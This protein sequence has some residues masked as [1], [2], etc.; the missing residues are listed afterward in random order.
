MPSGT[1]LLQELLS[2][3]NE[4]VK[5]NTNTNTHTNVNTNTNANTNTT[6]ASWSADEK[7]W[8]GF[9]AVLHNAT[10]A[11]QFGSKYSQIQI[12]L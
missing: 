1:S 3:V 6:L 11:A 5:S 8:T 4:N 10:A 12:Q 9:V 7:S 2:E